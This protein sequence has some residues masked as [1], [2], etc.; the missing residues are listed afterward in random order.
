[1]RASSGGTLE[2]SKGKTPMLENSSREYSW[3]KCF[4]CEVKVTLVPIFL[5]NPYFVIKKFSWRLKF[6]K[7][8]VRKKFPFP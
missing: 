5:I 7:K 3:I 2:V 8:K 4:R 1:M 6:N